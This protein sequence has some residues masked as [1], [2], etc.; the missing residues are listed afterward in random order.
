M[1]ALHLAGPEDLP[2]LLP[3]VAAFH[4]EFGLPLDD[5]HR[6]QALA[7]LL[8]GSPYGAVWLM[9]PSRAPI[10]YIILTFGWSVEFGGMDGFVDELYVRP[11]VRRRGIATE[12]LEQLPKTLAETG[13]RA[14]HL[15]V[16]EDDDQTVKMY[17]RQL[18]KPREGYMLMTKKI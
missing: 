4:E 16:R 8:D 7:P 6:V 5:D 14:L 12:V 10:G 2:R 17:R 3:L 13:L 1:T 18:F 9:G 11:A 15:E